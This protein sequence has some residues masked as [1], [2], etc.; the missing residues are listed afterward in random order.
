[1]QWFTASNR[2]WFQQADVY[3]GGITYLTLVI[4]YNTISNHPNKICSRTPLSYVIHAVM[5]DV[6]VIH[7]IT[8]YELYWQ[9]YSHMPSFT[10]T[11]WMQNVTSEFII[12]TPTSLR[13]INLCPT[14]V[15]VVGSIL[16]NYI[17]YGPG[18]MCDNCFTQTWTTWVRPFDISI[19]FPTKP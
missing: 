10:Y 15:L 5:Y 2:Q 16:I 12:Q 17:I 6:L 19:S 7:P 14:P 3:G 1:M 13:A 9:C 4:V 18:N 11:I 8:F